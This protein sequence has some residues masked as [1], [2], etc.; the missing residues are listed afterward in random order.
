MEKDILFFLI[1]FAICM[2]L[3]IIMV[4]DWKKPS[5]VYSKLPAP[6][7]PKA[8]EPTFFE[9]YAV[10]KPSWYYRADTIRKIQF[11]YNGGVV[12]T[13]DDGIEHIENA[14]GF[15]MVTADQ[16]NDLCWTE[17]VEQKIHQDL[18]EP[19]E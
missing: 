10:H 6:P 19:Q 2:L 5:D 11:D 18:Y 8:Q 3:V 7:K 14:E 1:M 9:V 4:H 16:V 17:R 15:R 12:I 13:T